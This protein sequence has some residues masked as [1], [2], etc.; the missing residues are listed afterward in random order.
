MVGKFFVLRI[1][2]SPDSRSLLASRSRPTSM[3]PL[4]SCFHS[5]AA[6]SMFTTGLVVI[7]TAQPPSFIHHSVN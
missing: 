7:S 4:C 2:L 5:C 3:V 6:T 1:P